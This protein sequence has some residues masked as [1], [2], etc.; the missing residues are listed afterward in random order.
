MRMAILYGRR[1]YLRANV[2]S[3]HRVRT[4]RIIISESNEPSNGP[5]LPPRAPAE[6]YTS[7]VYVFFFLFVENY[8]NHSAPR[9]FERMNEK[10]LKNPPP[11]QKKTAMRNPENRTK[12]R[13]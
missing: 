7:V 3:F 13:T 11:P 6:L 1:Y 10:K 8:H 5:P 9:N 4:R 12:Y 2:S